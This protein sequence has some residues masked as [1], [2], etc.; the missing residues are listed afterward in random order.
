[1]EGGR[2]MKR[3]FTLIELIVVIIVIGILATLAVPQY[4]RAVER[5]RG[6]KARHCLSL[7]AQAEKM[8]YTEFSNY[9]DV[10]NSAALAGSRLGNV[11]ELADV[12][13]DADWDFSIGD[14]SDGGSTFTA[15]AARQAGAYAS[16]WTITIDQV[17]AL[18]DAGGP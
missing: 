15:T 17:G 14:V 11:V 13:G 2:E 7:I 16:T 3:G 12:A 4:L 10:A 18:V 8:Y 5:T 6:A 1:L 9:V